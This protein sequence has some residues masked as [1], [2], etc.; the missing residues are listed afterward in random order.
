MW[1]SVS[2]LLYSSTNTILKTNTL[3]LQIQPS[4]NTFILK[5]RWPPGLQKKNGPAKKLRGRN[6]VYDLVEDTNVRAQQLMEVIL[7]S[8][9][10]GLGVAGDVVQ[11]KPNYAYNK[12]LLPKLGV[13]KTPENEAKYLKNQIQ[14]NI[15]HSSPYAPKTQK[16]LEYMLL[17][18]TMNKDTAWTIEPWHIRA[19]FRK[20]GYH[21]P[22]HAITLPEKPINGPDL[23]LEGKEFYVTVTINKFEKA[24]VKCRLHHWSTE[25][26]ERLPFIYEFWK[27]PAEAIFE[28]QTPVLNKLQTMVQPETNS[29]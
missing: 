9:V 22:E 18:V 21:V 10:E 7:T 8:Y 5:R 19:S 13:Y 1:R 28:E 3:D 27:K 29:I 14:T 17:H 2:K 24:Q 26:S 25:P 11:V 20:S 12:L 23:T 4:R 16:A 15:Q 6:F